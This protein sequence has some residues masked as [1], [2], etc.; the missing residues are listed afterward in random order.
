[1]TLAVMGYHFQVMTDKLARA[2]K[3]PMLP[4]G[5]EKA[6]AEKAGGE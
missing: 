5:M 1:M 4:G 2:V 6:L 3:A